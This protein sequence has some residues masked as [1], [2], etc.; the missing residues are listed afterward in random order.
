MSALLSLE[1]ASVS[2]GE[3]RV[4]AGADLTVSAG[5]L[6]GVLGPNG[7][8]KTTL[9]RAALGLAKLASGRARLSGRDVA[10][11]GP[12]ER[13][14]L[15]AYLPQERRLAW[16]LAA[17]RV[18]SLGAVDRPPALARAAALEA[19]AR[20]EMSRLA[21]RGVLEMSGGERAR[22]LLARLLATRAPLLVADEPV[23]GLDAEAQFHTLDLL[24]EETRAGRAVIVTLHDL[25]LAARACD[26]IVVVDKGRIVADGG[27]PETLTPDCLAEVFGLAGALVE[28]RAGAVLAA[29]RA[30]RPSTEL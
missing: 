17:W 16:S 20:V 21:D 7:A 14:R 5:E 27:V 26:R 13:A 28:T 4:L 23:A 9:L 8:G 1:G 19:L 3:R 10:G 2:L 18:A 11:L 24:R 22:V 12:E 15:V 6:V 25:T 30:D 29:R